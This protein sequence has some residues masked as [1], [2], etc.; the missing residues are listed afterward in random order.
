MV[1]I[2]DM[3]MWQFVDLYLIVMN[4]SPVHME[5]RKTCVQEFNFKCELNLIFSLR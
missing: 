4:G 1:R 5:V 2:F 3:G